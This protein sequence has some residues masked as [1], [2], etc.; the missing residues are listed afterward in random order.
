MDVL[1][2]TLTHPK[3]TWLPPHSGALTWGQASRQVMKAPKHPCEEACVVRR[4]AGEEPGLPRARR[5]FESIEEPQVLLYLATINTATI[6][7]E[8]HASF[9]SVLMF[10]LVNTQ[11][12]NGWVF[13]L[14]LFLIFEN[15]P[16]WPP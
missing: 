3:G 11:E 12:W 6:N 2:L 9:Q 5:V 8:L 15:S 13:I 14:V 4:E 7:T 16:C 1:E 10:S